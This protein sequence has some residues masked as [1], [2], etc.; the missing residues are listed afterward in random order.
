MTVVPN[1]FDKQLTVKIQLNTTQQ[2]HMVLTDL[3]GREIKSLQTTVAPG[4]SDVEIVNAKDALPAGF[5]FLS[6]TTP[7][8]SFRYKVIRN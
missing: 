4:V 2:V 3:E 7:Q 1:P 6:I 5:Y 8:G